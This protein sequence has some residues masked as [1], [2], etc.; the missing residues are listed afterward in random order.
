MIVDHPRWPPATVTKNSKNMKMTISV[1]PMNGFGSN[2]IQNELCIKL[3]QNF[4]IDHPKWPH[5][6][7]LKIEKKHEKDN[8]S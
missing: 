4:Q 7:L 5:P 8:I 6:P 3:L 2:L 1:E